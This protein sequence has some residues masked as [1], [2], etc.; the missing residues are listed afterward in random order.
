VEGSECGLMQYMSGRPE[1]SFARPRTVLCTCRSW[2]EPDSS[3]TQVRSINR[4]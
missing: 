4:N 2:I 1:E 3:G